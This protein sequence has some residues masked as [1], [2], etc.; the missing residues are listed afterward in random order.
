MYS[1]SENCL[2]MLC[3]LIKWTIIFG[4]VCGLLRGKQW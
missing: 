3:K 1:V 4:K 2:I